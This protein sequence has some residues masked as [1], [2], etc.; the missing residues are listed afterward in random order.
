MAAMHRLALLA[1]LV[2]LVVPATANAAV[3]CRDR[4]YNDWYPD[5]KIATTYPVACYRDA[6]K[7]VK[8]DA[9]VYSSLTD[10]IRSA[11]QVALQRQNG[12][13]DVPSAVGT[14]GKG[15]VSPEVTTLPQTTK[16]GGA[17]SSTD[18]GGGTQPVSQTTTIASAPTGSSGGGI[19]VPILVLGGLALLLAAIGA[20]GMGAKRFRRGNRPA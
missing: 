16:D 4:I 13:K 18:A 12:Q 17:P 9:L 8:G 2:V 1:F 5:G 6:L 19:P 7:H 15:A 11:M 10:D 14:G 3:P 20:V